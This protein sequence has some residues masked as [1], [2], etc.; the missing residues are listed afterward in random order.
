MMQTSGW[1][2]VWRS[3]LAV[4]LLGAGVLLTVGLLFVSLAVGVVLG[5][6]GTYSVAPMSVLLGWGVAL[7]LLV[8]GVLWG[9][10]QLERV[11]PIEL[12]REIESAQDL[13][14]GSIAGLAEPV[15]DSGSDS[16]VEFADQLRDQGLDE[17]VFIIAGAGPLASAR[18]AEWIRAN[19]PGVHIP[20][21]I[22][23]R[24][25]G[26]RDQ[27]QEGVQIC[28]DM[29]RQLKETPGVAGVHIMA[30]RQEHRVGEIVERSGVLGGRVPWHPRT[31]KAAGQTAEM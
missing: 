26:A 7:T 18:S 15:P 11:S 21:E 12:A 29:I 14:Q 20:D 19:V 23:R 4:L 2:R 8:W 1:L 25:K 13:R 5:R 17:K 30:F 3:R 22:V 10:R 27:A 6:L 31:P 28:V 24:L 9:R 16:L